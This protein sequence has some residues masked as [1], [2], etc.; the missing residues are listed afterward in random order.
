M[1]PNTLA[2]AAETTAINWEMISGLCSMGIAVLALFISV[3]NV[4]TTQKHNRL[5][6]K[7]HL[8]ANTKAHEKPR[9]TFSIELSNNGGGPALFE[10]T[11]LFIDEQP[12]TEKDLFTKAA[13]LLPVDRPNADL[14]SV[15]LDK[16][17]S[18]AAGTT[19]ELFSL[20]WPEETTL[21][22][23]ELED[24]AK[25]VTVKIKYKSLHNEHDQL[26]I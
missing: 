24:I 2:T 14:C 22:V 23:K 26:N 15:S 8:S 4:R 7:P 9:P 16:K 1:T 20:T 19:R 12:V 18:M 21:S 17:H 3:W 6:L 11:S 5:S 10:S 25:R 13:G